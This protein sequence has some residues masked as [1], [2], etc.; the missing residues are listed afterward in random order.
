M[1][2]W[3]ISLFFFPGSFWF[4]FFF[5]STLTTIWGEGGNSY[6]PLQPTYH[7]SSYQPIYLPHFAHPSFV[8]VLASI[9]NA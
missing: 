9:T 2:F 8:L 4:F 3:E 7:L 5:L 1:F 6:L